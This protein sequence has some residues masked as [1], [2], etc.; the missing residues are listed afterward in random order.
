MS[1]RYKFGVKSYKLWDSKA[2]KVVIS[3][4]VIFDEID[5]FHGSST[6]ETNPTGHQTSDIQ[7]ELE[8]NKS[9]TSSKIC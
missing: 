3:R 1:L 6:K 9:Q 7:V 2:S 5:M 4:N 8:I